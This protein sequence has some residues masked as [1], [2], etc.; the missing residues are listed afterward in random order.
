MFLMRTILVSLL[1]LGATA[2]ADAADRCLTRNEQKAKAATHAVIPLSRAMRAVRPQG[3][4]IRAR[5]CE[6]D[7]RL[8]YL[9]T[10]LEH[11]GKVARA[12]ID[13]ANGAVAG[14]RQPAK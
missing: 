14:L 2:G 12:V 3:E 7:G 11:D 4:I 8:V 6:H 9:L 1:V 10:L 5:L 13:A